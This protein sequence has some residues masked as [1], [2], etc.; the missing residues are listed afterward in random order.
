MDDVSNVCSSIFIERNARG[1][2]GLPSFPET[3]ECMK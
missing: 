3:I 2:G 1:F